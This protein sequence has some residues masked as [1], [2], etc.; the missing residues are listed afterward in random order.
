MDDGEGENPYSNN[1][2]ASEKYKGKNLIW[3]MDGN[4][5]FFR[6]CCMPPLPRPYEWLA[7]HDYR[8]IVFWDRGLF[9]VSEESLIIEQ[10]PLG[11]A[12]VNE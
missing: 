1:K 9:Q 8:R 11:V 5:F 10:G 6:F 4:G 3:S 2:S 12:T 7:H